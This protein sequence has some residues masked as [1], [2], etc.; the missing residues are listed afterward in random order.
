M[1]TLPH[2]VIYLSLVLSIAAPSALSGDQIPEK[3][4]NLKI[5]PATSS[6]ADVV[7]VMRGFAG[8]LGVRCNHC[9]VG[10]N[11]ANLDNYD[12]AS[13]DKEPKRVA[14]AM[15]R[16]TQEIN[17]KLVPAAGISQPIQVQCITCHRG[18]AKPEQLIDVLMQAVD[19][20]G[21]PAA[22]QQY[23]DLRSRYYG[24]GGYDFGAPT[25]NT[26][27]EWL[28]GQRKDVAAAIEVQE[29][30][31]KINPDI[32]TSYGLL[33][34]LYFAKGDRAAAQASFERAVA[35]DPSSEFFKKRLEDVKR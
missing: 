34:E 29:F 33:G 19:R 28:N 18:I 12:F 30:N 31:V 26:L 9:H 17:E 23:R 14:R 10:E 27:A 24:R 22:L 3:F 25:L 21:V 11:P 13:D 2:A 8:A 7:R 15:M 5:L 1:K 6:R 4:K 20:G 16:M 35:L 32:A